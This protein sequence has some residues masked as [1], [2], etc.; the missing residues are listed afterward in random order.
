M[1]I[2]HIWDNSHTAC[3]YICGHVQSE[4]RNME[5]MEEIVADTNYE[6]LQQFISSSPWD[7]R[8]VLNRVSLETDNLIGGTGQTGLLIDES[9]FAKKRKNVCWRNNSHPHRKNK[10]K[11]HF[12]RDKSNQK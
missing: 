3:Q 2:C 1:F 4:R 8:K 10:E 6:A 11:I 7:E 5:R 9:C 12:S